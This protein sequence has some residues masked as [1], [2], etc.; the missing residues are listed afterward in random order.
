MNGRELARALNVPERKMYYWTEKGW[1]KPDRV[2]IGAWTGEEMHFGEAEQA[3]ARMMVELTRCGMYPA[4]ASSIARGHVG[5]LDRLLRALVHGPQ[6]VE[7]CYRLARDGVVRDSLSRGGS[8]AG[9]GD[10][11][12]LEP[13]G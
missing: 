5:R 6:V 12:G 11:A 1:L 8:R 4:A 7:L 9:G 10:A 3:V 2:P 13:C